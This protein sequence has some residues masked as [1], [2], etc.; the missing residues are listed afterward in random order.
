MWEYSIDIQDRKYKE[1]IM[2]RCEK[3]NVNSRSN[4]EDSRLESVDNSQ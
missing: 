1:K 3:N 4:K 2:S